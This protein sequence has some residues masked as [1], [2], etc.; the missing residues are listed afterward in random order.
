MRLRTCATQVLIV[1]RSMPRMGFSRDG[2]PG[3]VHPVV[4]QEMP[5]LTA[6][7]SPQARGEAPTLASGGASHRQ[8][9]EVVSATQSRLPAPSGAR[10][11]DAATTPT[12][13]GP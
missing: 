13:I 8:A 6:R 11:L 3:M 2:E 5:A 4:A 12:N 7:G 10:K 9:P 1:P